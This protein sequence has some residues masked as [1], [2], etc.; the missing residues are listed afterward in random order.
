VS[1]SGLRVLVATDHE[2]LPTTALRH[3]AA[4]AEEGE[5]VLA[6]VLVVPHAQSLTAAL[7]R[8]VSS[9]C[10]MLDEAERA[11]PDAPGAFDTRL[12]RARSF[13]EGVLETLA[14]EPF[15]VLVV[16]KARGGARN[17]GAGQ[18]AALLDRAPPT[19]VLVRPALDGPVER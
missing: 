15:D 13:A 4:L 10:A 3:A 8:A 12:V 1:P 6:S 17:G 19:F 18:L 11:A 9:A 14:S 2:R 16:E 7:D 5:V